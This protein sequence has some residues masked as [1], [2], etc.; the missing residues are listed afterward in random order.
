MKARKKFNADSKQ[1]S[2]AYA[3][4]CP[5]G[6]NSFETI[7]QINQTVCRASN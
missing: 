3:R 1:G 7:I 4:I 5:G 6:A 2:S